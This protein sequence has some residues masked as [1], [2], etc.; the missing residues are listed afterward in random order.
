MKITSNRELTKRFNQLYPCG[1]SNYRVPIEVAENRV[2]LQRAEGGRVWDVD[3]NEYIDYLGAMGAGIL[4]HRHPEY[5]QALQ[6][7]ME[8][9]SLAVGSGVLYSEDDIA[10]AEKLTQHIPCA[11]KVK[12]CLSGTEAVQMA[13]RLARAYTNRQH[14]IRF[15]GHYHG[16]MDNVLGGMVNRSPDG[17]PFA[18][19][20][21]GSKA[22]QDFAFTHGRAK[23]A[24]EESFLLPWNDIEALE[25]TLKK[26]GEE[27]ALIHFEAMVCNHFCMMPRPGYLERMRELCN[28]YGIVMSIDEIITGFRI[29]LDGAQG[30]FGVT[31]DL[32]TLGKSMAGGLPCSAV[33]GKT[34]IMDQLHD[35]K[36][37]GPGTFNGYP[38]GMH[39]V[40]TTLE[41][42]E[43]DEGAAYRHLDTIQL[44]LTEG[45]NNL[46]IK[47]GLRLKIQGATGVFYT[48][49]GVETESDI[50]TDD[51]LKG[52][53]YRMNK[54]FWTEMQKER[55]IFF[56]AGGRW[57]PSIAHTRADALET[58]EAADRVM[59]RLK[60]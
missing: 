33:V 31:P 50:Y 18:Y 12:F 41:I 3:G 26:Y 27:I 9:R 10:V 45:L 25:N 36:V 15:D 6:A 2:F 52:F 1:H 11:E 7:Y 51:D 57:W 28:E 17:K 30:Y 59:N 48:L 24:L 55:V 16:W 40:R 22:H 23:G 58:L 47:H 49:F 19:H 46:A 4:G 8:E 35:G 53:D 60:G 38:I 14:F 54:G 21:S 5:I 39:A 37:L 29:G 56:S 13:I 20:D 43:K 44:L 42:L 32:A 34:E